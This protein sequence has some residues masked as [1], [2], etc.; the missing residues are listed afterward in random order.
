MSFWGCDMELAYNFRNILKPT[1]GSFYL[2]VSL[3]SA[4]IITYIFVDYQS[5]LGAYQT[6]QTQE[7]EAVTKKAEATLGGLKKL[8]RLTEARIYATYGDLQGSSQAKTQ[9]PR[10]DPEKHLLRIQKILNSLHQL[11]FYQTPPELQKVSYSKLSPPQM[12]ITR[13]GM[14]PLEPNKHAFEK[15]P[16]ANKEPLF[17]LRDKD[18]KATITILNPQNSLEGI[19]EIEID[20]GAFKQFLGTYETIDIDRPLSSGNAIETIKTPY[21]IS[22]S[23]YGKPPKSFLAYA[24]GHKSHYAVFVFY[25]LFTLIVIGFYIYFLDL[26]LHK[27]YHNKFENLEDTLLKRDITEKALKQELGKL[28]QDAKI[29]QLSCQAQKKLQAR[30]KGWQQEQASHMALSLKNMQQNFQNLPVQLRDQERM[31]FLYTYLQEIH[32]L[33]DGLWRSTK[34]EMVDFEEILHNFKLIFSEKIHKSAITIETNIADE[35]SLCL[36]DPFLLEL[37]LISAIGKPLHRI[38]KDET[39]SISLK[40]IPDYIHL[41]IRDNGYAGAQT[42]EKLV[43]KYFDLFMTEE[44]F[45]QTCLHNGLKYQYAK[46]DGFNITHIMIPTLEQEASSNNVV[47]LFT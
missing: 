31:E 13:F 3:S 7:V 45:H 24:I 6:S 27:S 36:G 20:F 26:H 12:I 46:A 32:V 16:P 41:E 19:L 15:M 35:V 44:T 8:L 9:N 22:F 2:F 14:F 47:K 1:L 18:I 5:Y 43:Q 39:I 4:F 25:I 21:S 11:Q 33:P 34:K 40:K 23:A 37:L 17:V 29:H 28:Q 30:L 10:G 42:K 38:S